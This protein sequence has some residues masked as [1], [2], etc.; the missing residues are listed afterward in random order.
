VAFA[1]SAQDRLMSSDHADSATGAAAFLLSLLLPRRLRRR[2]AVASL[3]SLTHGTASTAPAKPEAAENASP[4]AT[5]TPPCPVTTRSA[6]SSTPST[7]MATRCWSP[8]C[9]TPRRRAWRRTWRGRH[10]VWM[11]GRRAGRPTA[12][13]ATSPGVSDC[14]Q[15]DIR[16]HSGRRSAADDG[17]CT[18]RIHLRPYAGHAAPAPVHGGEHGDPARRDRATARCAR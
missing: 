1:E 17:P 3:T 11:G 8:S 15:F 16:R 14:A 9:L 13:A 4:S 2:G 5:I 10:Y 6:S 12:A 18:R 7:A